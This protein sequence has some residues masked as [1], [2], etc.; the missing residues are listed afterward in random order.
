MSNDFEFIGIM[1]KDPRDRDL[2]K[3]VGQL[4]LKDP[5]SGENIYVDTR[6]ISKA[7]KADVLERENYITRIFKQSRGDFLLLTT[8]N[9]D[10]SRE[11]M[12][13][14]HDRSTRVD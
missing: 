4:M 5:Y 10:Y 13:F 2:P 9:E 7:Y 11:L 1:V 14:F 3:D 6:K 12:K 8:D